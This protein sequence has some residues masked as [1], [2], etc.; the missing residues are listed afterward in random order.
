MTTPKNEKTAAAKHDKA[1]DHETL[2]SVD[3]PL[4]AAFV[5][6]ET[7]VV[8][9]GG[10]TLASQALDDPSKKSKL[11]IDLQVSVRDEENLLAREDDVKHAKALMKARGG[12]KADHTLVRIV[13]DSAVS[14]GGKTLMLG[15]IEEVND[16]DIASL[17]GRFEKV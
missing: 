3:N 16:V 10:E 8:K 12:P 17:P 15:A 7:P 14:S 6:E 13:G 11:P 2:T 5:S 1:G 4:P 9:K